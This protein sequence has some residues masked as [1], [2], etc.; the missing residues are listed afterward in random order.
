MTIDDLN[1]R[2]QIKNERESALA[3]EKY[4]ARDYAL[5]MARRATAAEIVEAIQ[6]GDKRMV[7]YLEES[8][9][10]FDMTMVG[11]CIHTMLVHRAMRVIGE[12]ARKHIKERIEQ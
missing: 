9:R 2:I 10:D 3:D 12:K 11:H 8:L 6:N 4:M 7:S 1:A 5:D